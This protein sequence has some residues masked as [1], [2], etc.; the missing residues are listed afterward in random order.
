MKVGILDLKTPNG[1]ELDVNIAYEK[2]LRHNGIESTRLRVTQPDFW[3][4]IEGLSLFIMRFSHLDS[5]L[6]IA[7]DILPVIEEGYSVRCFPNQSTSWHY[8]DKVKQYFFLNAKGYPFTKSWVF[9]DKEEALGWARSTRYP[10]V[11]KLRGGAGSSNVILV[12]GPR[13]ARGLIKRAFGRGILPERFFHAGS[14]RLR[15]FSLIRELHHLG[16]NAY[17]WIRGLDISPFWQVNKNYVYFQKFL[18]GNDCDTRV[19]VI[20]QRAFAFR[21]LVREGD[22]RASG[23]NMIDY[24]MS[25]VDLRCVELALRI[26]R[27]MNFQSMAYDFIV[28][29]S[30]LPEICEISYT[31]VSRAV[32]SCPGYWDSHLNWRAGN[33]WPEYL[34]LVDALGRDDLLVPDLSY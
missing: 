21:R 20:G 23:S 13:E 30:G 24:D 6:Q 34:H 4:V 15:H 31:Y 5:Q 14:I 1:G 27:E 7:R 9:Y 18:P 2:I 28:N 17:R 33:Y 8:D 25:K 12:N 32:Y 16:G 29:E 26:S 11:F 19:T 10:I 3:S 22:F